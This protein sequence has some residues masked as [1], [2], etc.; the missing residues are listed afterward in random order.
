MKRKRDGFALRSEPLGLH[1]KNLSQRDHED[2]AL[3]LS[4]ISVAQM[5]MTDY[6]SNNEIPQLPASSETRKHLNFQEPP[7][8]LPARFLFNGTERRQLAAL[9]L[10]KQYAA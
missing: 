8:I 7:L 1:V 9:D 4:E 3:I 2:V 5:E 6:L 10:R